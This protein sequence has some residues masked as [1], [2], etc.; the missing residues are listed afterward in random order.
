MHNH[1]FGTGP[2]TFLP[3]LFAC[4]RSL[5]YKLTPKLH[6]NRVAGPGKHPD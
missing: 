5:S 2:G 6:G 1:R 3:V 4:F